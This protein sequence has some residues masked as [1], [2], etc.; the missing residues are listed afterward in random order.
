MKKHIREPL[1]E[2][3]IN[4]CFEKREKLVKELKELDKFIDL[5]NNVK[6]CQADRERE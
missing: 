2:E 5:L 4:W 3:S 1:H 6:I